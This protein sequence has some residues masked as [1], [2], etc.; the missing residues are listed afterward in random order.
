MT[1]F[2]KGETVQI[3]DY[4][5]SGRDR[6][7]ALNGH[8]SLGIVVRASVETD[9][10]DGGNPLYE[11]AKGCWLVALPAGLKSIHSDWLRYPREQEKI[12]QQ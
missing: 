1:S 6:K 10:T 8:G 2:K 12:L 9:L 4:M 5:L 7:D 3:W 11:N